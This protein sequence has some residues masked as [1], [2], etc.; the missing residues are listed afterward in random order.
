MFCGW[1]EFLNCVYLKIVAVHKY[2]TLLSLLSFFLLA[3]RASLR[4]CFWSFL[5]TRKNF[6]RKIL[7][8]NHGIAQNLQE[9]W[10][11]TVGMWK[12]KLYQ[13]KL[14]FFHKLISQH[15]LQK[16]SLRDLNWYQVQGNFLSRCGYVRRY[17][18]FPRRSRFYFDISAFGWESLKEYDTCTSYH[19][20]SKRIKIKTH[21]TQK[22]KM[23]AS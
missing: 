18:N 11:H 2:D 19:F 10:V 3:K 8:L 17:T 12:K 7:F 9:V 4:G 15:L 6:L 20:A 16:F 22:Q 13:S 5:S 1:W 21:I 23:S 14:Y